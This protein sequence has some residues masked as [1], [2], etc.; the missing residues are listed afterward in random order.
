MSFNKHIVGFVHKGPSNFNGVNYIM[1]DG[2]RS[3]LEL[4]SNLGSNP[5]S[6]V[7]IAADAVVRK[8]VIHGNY[9]FGGVQFFDGKGDKILEAG[10]IG[11]EKLEIVLAEGERLLGIESFHCTGG[12]PK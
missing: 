5:W 2:S 7:K 1:S 4:K 10:F 6:D 9:E 11:P 8:V 3:Q 12:P